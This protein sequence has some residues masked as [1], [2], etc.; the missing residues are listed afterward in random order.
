[1]GRGGEE[2]GRYPGLSLSCGIDAK[3]ES[4]E[5][6]KT[7]EEVM[8]RNR[9]TPVSTLAALGATV[10]ATVFAGWAAW[11]THNSAAETARATQ[12]SVWLQV[13]SEYAQPE[14]L[15]AMKEL[16]SWQQAHPKDFDSRFK[17]LL[18]RREI[19]AKDVKLR[20]KLD[21]SRR[22]VSQFFTKIRVLSQL[23]VIN[24]KDIGLSWDRGTYTFVTDVLMPMERAKVEVL[25][26]TKSITAIDKTQADQT[27]EDTLKFL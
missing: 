18:L 12:A 8:L 22:R 17:Q 24:E 21:T 15:T 25:F 10:L 19:A 23:K 11:E 3:P 14:M 1:V 2:I 6:D 7:M 16:R 4:R 27:Q 9:R 5:K 20:D 26:A 13:L